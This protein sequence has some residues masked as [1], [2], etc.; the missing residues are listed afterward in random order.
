M[1][2]LILGVSGYLG[3]HVVKALEP[4]HKLFISDIKP[5]ETP[6]RSPF[7]MIDVSSLEQVMR[8][9]EGMDAI[10]NL[11]VVRE[12]RRIAFDVNCRGCYNVM[13]AAVKHKIRR[14]INTGPHFTI[15]GPPYEEFDHGLTPDMPPQ[16]GT[17]LY[18]LTKAL[19]QDICRIFT[20]THDIYV[21]DY[22]FYNFR[23]PAKLKRGSGGVPFLISDA[24][25]GEVFRCGLEIDLAKLPSRCEVFFIMA[26]MPQ[27]KFLN[28]KTKRI[29]G[30]SPKDDLAIAWQ[31]P[32]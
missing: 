11:S 3:R 21:Q 13:L 32:K 6:T 29:L 25:S 24:D 1:K 17:Y 15:T 7:T 18:A 22:L 2:V 5:Y 12:H 19:G 16:S 20:E 31:K 10:I 8:A 4:H 30:F 9:S 23:D 27:G 26:D 28:E 14:V